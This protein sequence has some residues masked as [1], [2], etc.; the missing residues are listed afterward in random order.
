MTIQG[1]VERWG[2]DSWRG[3]HASGKAV[4]GPGTDRTVRPGPP[5][6]QIR[7]EDAPS[8]AVAGYEAGRRPSMKEASGSF[9]SKD[10]DVAGRENDWRSRN[11]A[12]RGL[13]GLPGVCCLPGMLAVESGVMLPLL[14]SMFW[15]W[16]MCMSHVAI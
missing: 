1:R 9:L 11:G 7:W 10:R 8:T 15:V 3:G 14:T 12:T 5:M 13:D 4:P 2:Q 6:A 16:P